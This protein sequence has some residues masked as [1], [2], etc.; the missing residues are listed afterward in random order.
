MADKDIPAQI[1]FAEDEDIEKLKHWWKRNG[2]G[3]IAGLVIG[4]TAVAGIN[5]WRVYS[6]HQAEE[7]SALYRQMMGAAQAN[8]STAA[9]TTATELLDKHGSSGYADIALLMLSRLAVE[10]G[11]TSEAQDYLRRIVGDSKDPALRHT[12]RLRLGLLALETGD[13]AAIE[14][15]AAADSASAFVSQ[16]QELLGDSYASKERW[17]EAEAA[18]DRALAELPGNS[19]ST[20]L[21][22]AKR[23]MTRNSARVQ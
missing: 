4:V 18:Y 20:R 22:T 1:H 15:L 12:A 3:I 19:L 23:N 7:A 17:D 9:M 5:G 10:R 21:L 6:E 16:Y 8:Q 2:T 14:Q 11:N 13:L